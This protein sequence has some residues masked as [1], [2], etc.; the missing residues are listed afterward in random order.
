[1]EKLN[2]RSTAD[3]NAVADLHLQFLGDSP[4]VKLGERFLRRFF[5]VKL[6][7]D[8]LVGVTIC[9]YEGRIIGFISYTPD[10]FAF[11]RRGVRRHF[12][13]LCWLMTV[14]LI[15]QPSLFKEIRVALRMMRERGSEARQAQTGLGEVISLV[16]VPEFQ[17]HVPEGGKSR[18][19]VRLF[20]EML[21]YFRSLAYDRIHLMVLPHNRASNILCSSMGCQFEKATVAGIVTH[22]YTYFLHGKPESAP[23]S[24]PA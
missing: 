10:P 14:S 15:A 18:L 22:R 1:M 3:V 6:V 8:G 21:A 23:E 16:S 17:K 7:Q 24:V 19:T 4:I 5:Y 9:R 13:Y 12:A 2:P 20:E 11:M